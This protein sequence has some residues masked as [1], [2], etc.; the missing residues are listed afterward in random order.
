VSFVKGSHGWDQSDALPFV[1]EFA[2]QG[3]HSRNAADDFHGDFELRIAN[4]ELGKFAIRNSQFEILQLIGP[5]GGIESGSSSISTT[6][7][8]GKW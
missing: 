4:F 1:A 6:V 7:P 3:L 8:S 5:S 2:A